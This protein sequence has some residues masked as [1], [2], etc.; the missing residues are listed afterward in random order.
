MQVTI[1]HGV[2][3]PTRPAKRPALP[4]HTLST[5]L[6]DKSDK[7]VAAVH[8]HT[9][10]CPLCGMLCVAAAALCAHVLA[11]HRGARIGLEVSREDPAA[12][13]M[14][15]MPG[16]SSMLHDDECRPR[17]PAQNFGVWVGLLQTLRAVSE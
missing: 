5:A 2:L 13:S 4:P 9:L 1:T 11:C 3:E 8:S 6:T 7:V 15:L 10:R 16:G 14:R 17:G 12:L